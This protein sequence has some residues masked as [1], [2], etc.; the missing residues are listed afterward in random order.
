MRAR[1]AEYTDFHNIATFVANFTQCKPFLPPLLLY[2]I[3]KKLS[4]R[5][6]RAYICGVKF[7][8]PKITLDEKFKSTALL[9]AAGD[10]SLKEALRALNITRSQFY[11]RYK[12]LKESQDKKS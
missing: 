3:I 7:G 9:Y 11:Y 6:Q 8:R 10:I 1:R 12:M 5:G 4:T 2:G